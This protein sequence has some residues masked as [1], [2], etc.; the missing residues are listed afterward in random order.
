MICTSYQMLLGFSDKG[1][2]GG[3]NITT[4]EMRIGYE[5]LFRKPEDRRPMVRPS[6]TY[7]DN[8]KIGFK[9]MEWI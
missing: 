4:E 3:Q 5:V 7:E 6:Y 2:W 8:I 1:G 9:E